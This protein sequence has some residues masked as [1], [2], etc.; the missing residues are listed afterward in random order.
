MKTKIVAT[1]GPASQDPEVLK[2]MIR[3]GV[4]VVRMNFSHGSAQEQ[5]QRVALVR[6]VNRQLGTRVALLADLQGPKIRTGMVP[7]DGITLKKGERIIFTSDPM[8][9][10]RE[11]IS[12]QYRYFARDVK[13]GDQIM[14]DDGKILYQVLETDGEKEVLLEALVSGTIKSRKGINLPDTNISMPGLT[15]KDKKDVETIMSLNVHWIALSFVRSAEDIIQLRELIHSYDTPNKPGIIAKIEKPEAIAEIDRIIDVSDGIMV[16]RGDLGIEI[17]QEKVPGL[18]KLLV[19]KCLKVAKPI[20]I[21]TQ[22]MEGM[23]S[24]VRPTRAEVSDV[25]NSVLDGADALMLSGETSVGNYPIAVVKTMRKIIIE[26]EKGDYFYHR[27][28]DPAKASDD[29]FISDSVL[30]QSCVLAQQCGA[31]SINTLTNS[32]YSAFKLSSQRPNTRLFIFTNKPHLV[33][34]LSLV[35]G[36][37]SFF[38]EPKGSTSKTIEAMKT[39]LREQGALKTGD[40]IIN[41]ASGPVYEFGKTNMLRL[42]KME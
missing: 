36:V 32:G 11:K 1:I 4:N 40:V 18:Q 13:P 33:E 27:P 14:V 9:G 12:V 21:A 29:R 28:T 15:E 16:A 20:I 41:L 42:G 19:K 2:A 38:L 5:E 34:M 24:N 30:N 23:I 26:A 31:A 37:E 10:T 7:E 6:E 35:W 3:A 39:I 25:A 17:P 22:M 8:L